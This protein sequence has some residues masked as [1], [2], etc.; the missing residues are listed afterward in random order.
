MGKGD[1]KEIVWAYAVADWFLNRF[2]SQFSPD[3]MAINGHR[4]KLF[5]ID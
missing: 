3:K 5:R 2:S 4:V 1:I